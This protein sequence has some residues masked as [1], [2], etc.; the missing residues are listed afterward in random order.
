MGTQ[1]TTSKIY[2]YPNPSTGLLNV[3]VYNEQDYGIVL[4]LQYLWTYDYSI[5]NATKLDLSFFKQW[6]LYASF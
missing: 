5:E 2:M 1:E 3:D 6:C 4:Y